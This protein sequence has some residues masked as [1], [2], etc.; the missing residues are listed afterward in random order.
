MITSADAD[1]TPNIITLGE[2]FNVS[3]EEPPIAGIAIR[4]ATYT[5]GLISESGEFVINLAKK[6]NLEQVWFCGTHSGRE[7]DKFSGCGLTMIPS[8]KVRP[9]LI[10]EC[11]VNLECRL[12][13]VH[14]VGDHDLFLGEV[15][16]AHADESVLSNDGNVDYDKLDMFCFMMNLGGPAEFRP[17]GAKLEIE[18]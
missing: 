1:G 14:E 6:A 17:I 15:V 4:K 2:V 16:A 9:P 10:A 11:P 18:F 12:H 3:L 13:A 8:T 5:H 7:V